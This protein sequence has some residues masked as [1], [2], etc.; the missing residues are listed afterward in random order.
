MSNKYTFWSLCNA[1][2]KIEIPIIQ[3]DYAQG[4]NTMEVQKLRDRFINDYLI[5][6]ILKNEN[7]ELDFVYGSILQLNNNDKSKI[8]FPL[9]GQQRLT[10]LTILLCAI[11][12]GY[13]ILDHPALADG[14]QSY[15]EQKNRENK[16]E[17][18]LQTETSF[19]YLQEEVLKN[20][21][22][23]IETDAGREE[24]AIQRAFDLFKA[25]IVNGIAS[26][27]DN[28]EQTAEQ[29]NEDAVKWLNKV[30]DSVFDLNVILVTL[31]NEDDAY[32]IFET[33]N[34]RGKDLA[35][36]DLL[37]NHF[38]KF[39]KPTSHSKAGTALSK[40]RKWLLGFTSGTWK[41]IL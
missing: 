10:T 26:I 28:K 11:R 6:S 19:P 21:T 24:E 13:K 40:A 4:R 5:D 3:R 35:L 16:T 15:I 7:I 33:L 32:L 25:H 1:Y 12:E 20:S 22:S 36:A 37:R 27:L 39:L 17:F 23:E 18:V 34:T 9:D 38:A 41:W 8:F 30:R 2:S 31:D 14:L 29:N